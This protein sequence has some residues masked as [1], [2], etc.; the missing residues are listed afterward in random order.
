MTSEKKLGN[1]ASQL[2]GGGHEVVT[3]KLVEEGLDLWYVMP[4]PSLLHSTHLLEP[5]TSNMV[6]FRK[7]R[8]PSRR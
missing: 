2:G 1:L 7:Y 4:R 3:T 6:A 8:P 5:R